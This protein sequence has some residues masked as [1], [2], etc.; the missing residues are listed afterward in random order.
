MEDPK[1]LRARAEQARRLANA[2]YTACERER[3]LKIADDCEGEAAKAE[4]AAS[5]AP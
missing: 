3:M 4:Q 1:I 5:N 2:M